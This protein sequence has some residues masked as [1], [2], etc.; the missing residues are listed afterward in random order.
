ML[1]RDGLT[2]PECQ[3]IGREIAKEHSGA[4]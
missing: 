4:R 2:M 3:H 1:A